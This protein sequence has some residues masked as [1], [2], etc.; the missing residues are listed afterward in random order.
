M[1]SE[2]LMHRRSVANRGPCLRSANPPECTVDEIVEPDG[3]TVFS[4]AP[5]GLQDAPDP[6]LDNADLNDLNKARSLSQVAA[7]ERRGKAKRLTEKWSVSVLY[8]AGL[9][10]IEVLV[11]VVWTLLNVLCLKLRRAMVRIW[12]TLKRIRPAPC[13]KSLQTKSEA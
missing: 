7:Y 11:C 4:A 9:L 3:I 1:V 8:T 6:I 10:L 5:Q 2:H 13:P 12:L